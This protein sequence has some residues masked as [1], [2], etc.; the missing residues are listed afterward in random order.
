MERVS[1]KSMLA[2]KSIRPAVTSPHQGYHWLS[3]LAGELNVRLRQ[4]REVTPGLWP[5]TLVLSH[6][7]G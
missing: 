6:R 2:S 1:T 3:I 5:K 4:S 7:Q